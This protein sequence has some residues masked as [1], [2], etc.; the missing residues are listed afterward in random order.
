ML[1]KKVE[2]ACYM[3]EFDRDILSL[4]RMVTNA[5]VNP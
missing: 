2:N 1:K 4:K 3:Y 5:D